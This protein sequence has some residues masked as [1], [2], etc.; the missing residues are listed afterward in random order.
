[1]LAA[2]VES[3]SAGYVAGLPG[4]PTTTERSMVWACSGT[5]EGLGAAL[6]VKSLVNDRVVSPQRDTVPHKVA[7]LRSAEHDVV[8]ADLI[9]EPIPR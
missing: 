4:W 6:F 9:D 1:M 3:E 2:T 7:D 5:V 8:D